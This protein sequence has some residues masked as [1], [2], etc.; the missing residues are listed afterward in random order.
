MVDFPVTLTN[1]IKHAF[2]KRKNAKRLTLNREPG[3][4][5]TQT[6]RKLVHGNLWANSAV[7]VSKIVIIYGHFH[8]MKTT[9]C[10]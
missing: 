2:A 5:S 8:L 7:S 10:P 1:K 9:V 3:T 4:F 6:D